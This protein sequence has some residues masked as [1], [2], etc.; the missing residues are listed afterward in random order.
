MKQARNELIFIFTTFVPFSIWF[1]HGMLGR[2]ASLW[3]KCSHS[4]RFFFSTSRFCQASLIRGLSLAG[5]SCCKGL[6]M[7][8]SPSLSPLSLSLLF[9]FSV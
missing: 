8:S 9:I 2:E 7:P 5:N 3:A 6:F 4:M 1:L